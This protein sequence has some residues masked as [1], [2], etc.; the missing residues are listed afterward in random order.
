MTTYQHPETTAGPGPETTEQTQV[1]QA[2]PAFDP[3]GD[4]TLDRDPF[5]AEDDG[6]NPTRQRERFGGVNWGAA[7]FG[8]MITVFL[9][10]LLAGVLAAVVTV[11]GLAGD[12]LDEEGVVER[13]T[14]GLVAAAALFAVLVV[15]YYAGGYVAGRMSRFDGGKQGVAVWVIA[16][17]LT[18][19][20]AGAGLLFGSQYVDLR[21]Y[22]L[23]TLPLPADLAGMQAVVT[24]VAAL[25]SSLLAAVA[26][27]KV[28]C[29]Y[30]RKVDDAAYL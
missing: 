2:A 7:L 10:G 6:Y 23:P 12:V 22:G 18:G 19:A 15:A 16:L 27:G 8:W 4:A 11:L 5:Y 20:A 3:R 25:L 29:R 17:L 26:G 9:G 30:H 21:D 14:P 28:G 13:T 24:G 1:H